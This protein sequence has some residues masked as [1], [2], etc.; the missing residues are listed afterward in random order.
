MRVC[1]YNYEVYIWWNTS[2]MLFGIV[3]FI[4]IYLDV[5]LNRYTL[6]MMCNGSVLVQISL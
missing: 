6:N 3:A 1:V 5:R 4:V 2:I